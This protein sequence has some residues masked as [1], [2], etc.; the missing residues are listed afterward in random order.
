MHFSVNWL[1]NVYVHLRID[2]AALIM[3]YIIWKNIIKSIVTMLHR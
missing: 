3:M 1:K 2:L